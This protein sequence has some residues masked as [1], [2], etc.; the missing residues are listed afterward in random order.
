MSSDGLNFTWPSYPVGD[1]DNVVASG[2][3]ITLS[4]SG[5]LALLGSASN[6]NA[7]GTLTVTYTDGSKSTAT[8][9]FS[10]WTLGGGG[11]Q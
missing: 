11:A 3:T 9:G 4:G 2:Q 7:Q 10:D 8:V 5:R 1:P 6:G